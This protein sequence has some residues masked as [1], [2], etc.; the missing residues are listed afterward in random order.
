MFSPRTGK[1]VRER[2]KRTCW[3]LAA[4]EGTDR[5]QSRRAGLQNQTPVDAEPTALL[6]QLYSYGRPRAS[7]RA[8]PRRSPLSRL[9]TK[10]FLASILIRALFGCQSEHVDLRGHGGRG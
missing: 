7:S 10:A 1:V 2:R 8:P 9:R 6:A 4:V 5:L 3:W